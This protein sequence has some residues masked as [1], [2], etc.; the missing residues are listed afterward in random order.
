[1]AA[2]IGQVRTVSGDRSRPVVF[3]RRGAPENIKGPGAVHRSAPDP[4]EV[5]SQRLTAP[6][7]SSLQPDSH[8]GAAVQPARLFARVVVARALFTVAHQLQPAGVDAAARQV[9]TH[10][11]GAPF[12]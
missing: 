8:R 9:L 12:A 1:M 2:A 11:G 6:A 7:R 3:D 4:A 10:R 5:A